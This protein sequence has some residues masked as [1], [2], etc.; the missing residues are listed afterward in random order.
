MTSDAAE[1]GSY[2]L[3]LVLRCRGLEKG[4][5]RDRSPGATG[6]PQL[7]ASREMST[8]VPRVLGTEFCQQPE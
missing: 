3:L 1:R 8:L 6:A 7:R 5:Q 4:S 2:T